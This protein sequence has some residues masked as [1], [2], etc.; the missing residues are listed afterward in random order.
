[1]DLN[2]ERRRNTFPSNPRSVQGETSSKSSQSMNFFKLLSG[3]TSSDERF[4]WGLRFFGQLWQSFRECRKEM[5]SLIP[6]I[7]PKFP[8]L[9][10][11]AL[12]S[13]RA[14]HRDHSIH[15]VASRPILPGL[16]NDLHSAAP[17]ANGTILW[18]T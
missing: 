13:F 9:Y 7:V 14:Y 11:S 18:I 15:L 10:L 12:D 2:L 4:R 17:S 8:N 3:K 16:I 6:F 5:T 1:M